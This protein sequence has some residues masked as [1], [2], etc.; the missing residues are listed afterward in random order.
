MRIT[1]T[2]MM[3]NNL[4][5]IN[6]NKNQLDNIMM[7]IAS[8]KKIQRPSEDPIA[9]IRA[10]RL[11]ATYNEIKQ[12]KD[13]NVEDAEAWMT[14]TKDSLDGIN[15]TLQNI[16]YYCNQG[17]NE[18]NT[19]DEYEAIISDLKEFREAIYQGGNADYG[20]RTIFTGY[21]T[22]TTLTFVSDDN[23]ISYSITEPLSYSDIRNINRVVG[24]DYDDIENYAGTGY[25]GTDITNENL[26]IAKLA[27]KDIDLGNITI[28]PAVGNIQIRSL[29]T[30]GQ[31][32]Y[33]NI[34][35][36]E[37]YFI[38]ETGELIFGDTVYAGLV[39]RDFSV[40]YTKTGFETGDLRP[41][42]Y[43]DCV[44]TETVGGQ[45]KTTT[46]TSKDQKIDYTVSFNQT[47]TV[48]VQGKDVLTHSMGRDVDEMIS[49]LEDIKTAMDKKARINE[50]LKTET[51]E[52]N[53]D[54]L[55]AMLEAAELELTYAQDN[56][57]SS[58]GDAIKYFKAHQQNVSV[59][60]SD[61][62]ARMSRLSM[63]S[64]RLEQQSLTVEE[65]KSKNED[66]NLEQAAVEWQAMGDVYDASLAAA[67][68]IVQKSL[69][70]FI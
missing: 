60:V 64:E 26:H 68:K 48:N 41:E 65:L 34:Q 3:N 49:R 51:N 14:V 2:I 29:E 42:H 21:K 31:E 55:N 52:V 6:K 53:I 33:N 63:I 40:T 62:A 54:S 23:D 37:V 32:A 43:F 59:E 46:Y 7:Q 45:T 56:I 5:N 28:T 17:V 50:K 12:Y 36:N 35:D 30:Q 4:A 44:K 38:P 24:V 16:I 57:T 22:D 39:D 9:A 11:R 20:D 25:V 47:L 66:T 58:F 61:L 67:A 70:D 8:T 18:Y 27:Y 10:L 15:T 19:A 69:L 13:R 1:N